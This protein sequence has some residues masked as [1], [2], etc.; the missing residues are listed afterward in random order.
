M[1][2]ED[3]IKIVNSIDWEFAEADTQYLTHNIHRYSGK[4]IPQIAGTAIDLLTAKGDLVL[5]SYMGSGTTL[6]E[7][8]L[9]ERNS[10]GI[11]LNP[12]AVLI[13]K[14]K[15]TRVNEE[16]LVEINSLLIPYVN[17]MLSC[18]QLSFCNLSFDEEKCKQKYLD[19]VWRVED[20]WNKK[21]YQEDVLLQLIDIYSC[22]DVLENEKAKNIALVAFSDILRKSSNASSRYPNVMFDKKAKKKA[23]PAKAFLESLA[24]VIDAVALLTKELEGKEFSTN[25]LQGNNLD[26]PFENETF[27]AIVSHPPYIAAIP[28]AEYGSLSLTW[29][30]YDCKELDSKLTGGKRH[31][32]KVV[33][34]FEEDYRKYFFESYRVLKPD[35]Y[36]F[37]L[38]GNPVAHGEKINLC[39][40]TIQYA[41]SAGFRHVVTAIRHGMNRRGNK[42][43]DEYLVFLQK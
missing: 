2:R 40:M 14:V 22:I 41:E 29:F 5:D 11:D 1:T 42:M 10:V 37:L 6:L 18:G 34:R 12:L 28:Y 23:L 38:V 16:D 8:S 19:N 9:R 43:G 27:D 21:W 36:M 25:I 13:S 24:Y 26:L 39:D 33:S 30:G 32:T 17:R 15:N 20:P 3:I 7:S 31:S 35:H 4:F